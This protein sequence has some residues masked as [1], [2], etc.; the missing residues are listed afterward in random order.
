M[1]TPDYKPRSAREILIEMKNTSDLV[2]ELAY[3]SILFESK[4]IAERVHELE[5]RMDDLMYHIRIMAA[6]AARN[7]NEARKI[8]GI[9]QVAGAAEAISNATGD[10]ADLILR[11]IEIH[12]VIHE[13]ILS[14]DEKIADV[15]VCKGSML[16]GKNFHELRLPSTIGVFALAIKRGKSWIVPPTKD[17]EVLLGDLL[18]VRGPGDGIDI[19]CKMAGVH[20]K[21]GLL[22]TNLPIIRD[23]LSHMRDMSS[24]MVD[25]AYSSI[26]IGSMEVAEEVRKLEEEFDKLNYKIWLET[27]KAAKKERDV[28]RL[29]SILQLAKCMEKISDAA[30]SIADVVLRK[31]EL[32]PV[33]AR[34]LSETD[35]QVIRVDVSKHSPLIG[36]TLGDLNLWITVGAYILVIK[37]EEHHIFDPGRDMKV[38]AGDS[39]IARGSYYGVQKLKKMAAG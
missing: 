39:L 36:K 17:T 33:F 25:M 16:T 9:L 20:R 32:H 22:K 19:L 31:V 26:F 2:V 8:T 7:V 23:A 34:A 13:A 18:I 28:A 1:Q 10:I 15:K 5:R 35:E 3:A 12:P 21:A 6:V 38:L 30:D 14:A 29:S 24:M 11:G 27:L 4:E 37:R